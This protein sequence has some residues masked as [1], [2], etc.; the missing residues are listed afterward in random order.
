[1]NE[2]L[3]DSNIVIGLWKQYPFVIDKLIK[4]KKIKILKE[5]SEELVVKEM[6]E[7]KGQR[8]LAQRFLSLISFIIEIDKKKIKEFYSM[9]NIKY[10]NKGNAYYATNK[11]SENDLLLLYACYLDNDFIL[12]TEDKYLFN[13]GKFVLGEHRLMTLRMLVDSIM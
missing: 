10:S 2:Y 3:L 1:M 6:R 5:I 11:L 13:T 9:I 4:D 8:I 7:Y 12:V